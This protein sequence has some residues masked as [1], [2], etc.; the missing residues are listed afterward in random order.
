MITVCVKY[1]P[2]LPTTEMITMSAKYLQWLPTT[3][4]I[5]CASYWNDY[6]VWQYWIDCNS[7]H[8]LKWLLC[9]LATEVITM[10]ADN[11]VHIADTLSD[12]SS[13]FIPLKYIYKYNNARARCDSHKINAVSTELESWLT[14][15]KQHE[16]EESGKAK[17][18]LF[19]SHGW[20]STSLFC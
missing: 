6:N 2:C 15:N 20:T 3:E 10:C 9:V 4:R 8:I 7:R 16:K 19:L 14:K 17:N 12:R 11:Y 13:S 5:M 1:L 18:K